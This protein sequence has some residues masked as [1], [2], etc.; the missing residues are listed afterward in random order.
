M[1]SALVLC[2]HRVVPDAVADDYWPWVER[3]SAITVSRFESILDHISETHR[4][5]DEQE[6]ADR[7]VR[8]RGSAARTCW[9]TFDDGYR[10]NLKV[11]A[12][13][14]KSRGISPT[15]FI[16]TRV[17]QAGFRLPVDRWYS[18]L[19]VARTGFGSPFASPEAR[20]ALLAGPAKQ[21]FVRARKQEQDILLQALMSELGCSDSPDHRNERTIEYLRADDLDALCALGWRIGPHGASHELLHTL[22]EDALE[23]ELMESHAALDGLP[24]RSLWTAWPDGAWN[25]AAAFAMKRIYTPLGYCG[26]L[27]VEP[28]CAAVTDPAWAMPRVIPCR[29]NGWACD[30]PAIPPTI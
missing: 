27:S 7:L 24:G 28:R 1:P 29:E 12:P 4:W 11:A 20:M 13:I 25:P 16:S 22:P 3:G 8:G 9:I 15:L 18:A 2:F 10:D 17:L 23:A 19:L 21:R 14:L 5:I 6:A 26:C 30:G